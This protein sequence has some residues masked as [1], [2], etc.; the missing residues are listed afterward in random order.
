MGWIH[1]VQ[2]KMGRKMGTSVF[3]PRFKHSIDPVSEKELR[4]S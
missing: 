2:M 4:Y 1:R 3:E